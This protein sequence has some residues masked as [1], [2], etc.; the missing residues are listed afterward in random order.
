MVKLSYFDTMAYYKA[1]KRSRLLI[2][3]TTLMNFQIIITLSR[4][5]KLIP[6]VYILCD[7]IYITFLQWQNCRDG[8]QIV[9]ARG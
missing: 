8:E 9:V 5:K 3:V 4:E 2:H 7:S 1:I 6:E